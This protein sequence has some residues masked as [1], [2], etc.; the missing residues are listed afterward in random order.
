[1]ARE[2]SLEKTRNIGIMAHIDAGKTTTTERILFYTGVNHKI[3]EVHEGAA[4]MDWM[5][6]EQERG[7]TITSASTT[8]IWKN[9]RIN[10]IDT[11]GHVDFTAE[12][13]RS[14][15]V[16]DGV[17]VVLCA[18]GGV[19]PQ[20]ETIWH[21]AER[22]EVPRIV[23]VNKMDRIG[24]DFFGAVE[25][26][27]ERLGAHG[28]PVELPL[29]KEDTFEG[30][31]DLITMKAI[32]YSS[33]TLGATFEEGEI[34]AD[35]QEQAEE[36][37]Q[38]LLEAAA[39][40][41]DALME[42]YLS[43]EE[44]TPDQ[45]HA[46][47]R[48]GT[49]KREIFPVFC[50][51]SFKNKGVQPLLD[52]VINYLPSPLD[53]PP[54]IGR[55]TKTGKEVE[56]KADNEAPLVGLVFKIATDPFAGQL[57]YIRV[58]SGVI[59]DG[60]TIYNAT[61]D[62]RERLGKLLHM[63]AA[64]REEIAEI[65]AGN[66]C[67]AVGLKSVRTGDTICDLK[68]QVVIAGMEFPEPVISVA[69]E[70][71]SKADEDKMNDA[72]QKLEFED[73][74]F[75]TRRDKETGQ[76]LISGMGELHLDIIVD[77]LKREFGVSAKVGK[78]Q[79]S[80]RETI[81]AT[82]EA[83]GKFIR[84]TGTGKGQYGHVVLRVEPNGQEGAAFERSC[85]ESE[86]PPIYTEAVKS[87]AF[88]EMEYGTL[89]GY[90]M[91]NIKTTLIGGSFNEVD[92][93]DLAFHAAASIAFRDAIKAASPCILEPI[94][95]TE[96]VA[97]GEYMGDIVGDINKRRGKVIAITPRGIL[98]I[99]KAKVPLA[100]MFGYATGLRSLT[101]GRASYSMQFDYYER[102]P[103]NIEQNMIAKLGGY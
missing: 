73:P 21:Q 43:G 15:R 54:V 47:L 75:T 93:S 10:V 97:P 17:I 51:S 14:M 99:I 22:Y 36:Y 89:A 60:M 48:I 44:I 27:K 87:G 33:E 28:V 16:L 35:Y 81:T 59:K 4:T 29:G 25:S 68:Q 56:I 85:K 102:V 72:L 94:M 55:H 31:I 82:A 3:G 38:N 42:A 26:L 7:I 98:Q 46:A 76:L 61:L 80:Y 11:P 90:Q 52:G 88:S 96:I 78:P 101:Q 20:S 41:D 45:I 19:E 79:V 40:Y 1:M 8:A 13:E 12:V 63:H 58:Y 2:Y 57:A 92:S 24:A 67:A 5:E 64:R 30:V 71:K 91:I 62:K 49:L 65:G 18:V 74:T 66:I 95:D 37:R 84:Q 100:E 23:F 34:P 70:P 86:V 53:V 77:R 32:R 9:Y 50:G 83:E 6:Q 69:L 103:A 39:E